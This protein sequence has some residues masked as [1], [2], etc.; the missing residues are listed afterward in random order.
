MGDRKNIASF[1]NIPANEFG[2][3]LHLAKGYLKVL[4]SEMD[5]AEISLDLKVFI[6]GEALRFS[7]NFSCPLARESP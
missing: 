6:K 5:P 2:L 7:A 3:R 1:K 4:P